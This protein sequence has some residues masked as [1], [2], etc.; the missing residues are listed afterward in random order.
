MIGAS[1]S[2]KAPE[3]MAGLRWEIHRFFPFSA[4]AA[5][6]PAG[7]LATT[8]VVGDQVVP[9]IR[10]IVAGTDPGNR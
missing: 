4:T 7:D 5:A 6:T 9:V 3:N 2:A 8:V 10:G 1:L